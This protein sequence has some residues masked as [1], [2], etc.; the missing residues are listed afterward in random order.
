MIFTGKPLDFDLANTVVEYYLFID[1]EARAGKS[2]D[3]RLDWQRSW[4][5]LGGSWRVDMPKKFVG[6]NSKAAAAKAR[7]NEKAEAEKAKK[8]KE[9]EDAK[10]ADDNK[11]LAKKQVRQITRNLC[12]ISLPRTT[13]LKS[14]ATSN[15]WSL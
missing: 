7:K 13:R 3:I 11:Q 1:Y 6:E 2:F 8:D 12:V 9:V 4:L 14:N 15:V 10:W 5:Q